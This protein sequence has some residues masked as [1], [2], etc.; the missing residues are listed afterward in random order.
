[1]ARAE[2]A[3]SRVLSTTARTHT[4]IVTGPQ[5]FWSPSNLISYHAF[6]QNDTNNMQESFNSRIINPKTTTFFDHLQYDLL[7]VLKRPLLT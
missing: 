5:Y 2:N 1:M 3:S 6:A 4:H 7:A